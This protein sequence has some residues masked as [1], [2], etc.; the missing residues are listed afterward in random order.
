MKF[1][2]FSCGFHS[3]SCSMLREIPQRRLGTVPTT[4]TPTAR[5]HKGT[6]PRNKGLR[7]RIQD[8][9]KEGRKA[10]PMM[11]FVCTFVL[12][13]CVF[14]RCQLP[15]RSRILRH[16]AARRVARLRRPQ[17]HERRGSFRTIPTSMERA[18]QELQDDALAVALRAL[19]TENDDDPASLWSA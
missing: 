18:R 3:L 12:T 4:V 10:R 19:C 6:T 14:G 15:S 7:A 5:K 11:W 9:W 2:V 13:F 1:C 8:L 17:K 16:L